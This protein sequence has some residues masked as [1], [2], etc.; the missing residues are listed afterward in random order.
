MAASDLTELA[1]E[2][3]QSARLLDVYIR[4]G[5]ILALAV[6]CFQILSPFVSMIAWSVILAVALYPAQQWLALR[7]GGRQG[8]AATLLVLVSIVLIVAPT[9][10]LMLA[11]GQS[12]QD[13]VASVRDQ[14]VQVPA[15]AQSVAEWPI[16]GPKLYALWERAYTDLPTLILSVLPRLADVSKQ[17]LGI[18]AGIG[19][20][21]LLFLFSFIIAGFVMAFG[22]AGARSARAIFSRLA[23]IERGEGIARLSTATIRAVAQGVIGVAF[24][25]AVVIGLLLLL[26]EVPFAGVLAVIAL[27]LGIA[28]LPVLLVNLPVIIYLW[29]NES[30]GTASAVTYTV[31]LALA[32]TLDNVLKPLTLGR[33][34]D[35]PMPVILLGA[36]G[37]MAGSGILGMFV[38]ATLLA[39]GYQLF[40]GWVATNP[41]APNAGPTSLLAGGQAGDKLDEDAQAPSSSP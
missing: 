28:Q 35:A 39:L 7:M 10:V 14:S 6:L 23:G 32:G 31:L 2:K 34:V 18:V 24:V 5:L 27:I 12:A 40:M 22:E 4:A 3:R 38:G 26:A 13:F 41:D 36:L 1:R 20:G 8:W 33:G 16:I 29:T 19:F 11:L 21:L 15:P 30:Y 37:G 17:A 25:Q 9:T